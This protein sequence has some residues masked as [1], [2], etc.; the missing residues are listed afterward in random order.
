MP[1]L[2]ISPQVTCTAQGR[3]KQLA[4]LQRQ[5]VQSS[6][7]PFPA[8]SL[9][10]PAVPRAPCEPRAGTAASSPA[11][12]PGSP[13]WAVEQLPMH[14]SGPDLGVSTAELSPTSTGLCSAPSPGRAARAAQGRGDLWGYLVPACA[15]DSWDPLP[16][17]LEGWVAVPL[18]SPFL[19]HCRC[20]RSPWPTQLPPRGSAGCHPSGASSSVTSGGPQPCPPQHVAV[21]RV[22]GAARQGGSPSCQLSPAPLHPVGSSKWL[23]GSAGVL[24]G[25]GGHHPPYL[26]QLS[27]SPWHQQNLPR[28]SS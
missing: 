21:P 18:C 17:C 19:P 3:H 9:P 28:G 5:E 22:S 26:L 20:P 27:P 7:D 11:Q 8:L 13:G 12:P 4:R 23:G 2:P 25:I 14:S 24:A 1:G 10:L 6:I 15:E 16:A